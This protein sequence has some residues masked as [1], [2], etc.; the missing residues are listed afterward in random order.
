MLNAH[1]LRPS[2]LG[3]LADARPRNDVV[4]VSSADIGMPEH[5]RH[6]LDSHARLDCD[7]RPRVPEIRHGHP[8]GRDSCAHGLDAP[9]DRMR[10]EGAEPSLSAR[11]APYRPEPHE[12]ESRQVARAG[13]FLGLCVLDHLVTSHPLPRPRMARSLSSAHLGSLSRLSASSVLQPYSTAASSNSISTTFLNRNPGTRGAW[14]RASR[15]GIFPVHVTGEPC[16]TI[17]GRR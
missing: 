11:L 14:A 13:G 5:H 7:R 6:R 9:C 4:L 10:R 3:I 8:W 1:H 15:S 12:G 17:R 2:S 16:K